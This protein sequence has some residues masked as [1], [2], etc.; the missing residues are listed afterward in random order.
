MR[1]IVIKF[2]PKFLDLYASKY[3]TFL[4]LPCNIAA[5]FIWEAATS[6]TAA[7]YI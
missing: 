4:T 2:G 3:G 5:K 6:T 1:K 7:G